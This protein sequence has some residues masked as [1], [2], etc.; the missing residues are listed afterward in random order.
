MACEVEGEETSG[1]RG[2]LVAFYN[3]T[4]GPNWRNNAS[5]LTDAPLSEWY[6]I[7]TDDGGRVS[8]LSLL[9]NGL[10]G[11]IPPELGRLSN[12]E[13]LGLSG[14]GLSGEIPA[15]LGN[16]INLKSLHLLANNLSGEIP[17]E[18]GEL[19]RLRTLNLMNNVLSGAIPLELG[20]LSNLT[21]IFL[22]TRNQFSG[23]IPSGF[24]NIRH[25]DFSKTG[26]PFC[27]VDSEGV[28]V[29]RDTLVNFYN[30]TGG[31]NWRE[32]TNWLTD[33]PIVQWYGVITNGSGRVT[34]LFLPGNSLSGE[35]PSV[36]G[37]LSNLKGLDL[38]GNQLS[39]EIPPELS[40]LSN[41]EGLSLMSNQL[42]GEIPREFVKLSNLTLLGLAYNRLSGQIPSVLGDLDKLD[43][44]YL[45]ENL[46][47]GCIPSDLKDLPGNDFLDTDL[48][49]CGS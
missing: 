49:F 27:E 23:C 41:L 1:D 10:S 40:R 38:S 48:P 26:L 22:S 6:G 28:V 39:G 30:A 31:P 34:T 2:V 25:N 11:G 36:L 16:L 7:T 5:W 44:L 46:L 9:A 47:D 4:D 37:K 21:G 18:L 29:D 20:R 3:A 35:I 43:T 13:I 33:A 17:V 45:S 8:E 24:E 14:D 32:S 12:L 42:T 19:R 15:E